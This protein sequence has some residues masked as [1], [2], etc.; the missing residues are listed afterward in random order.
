MVLIILVSGIILI[1]R[2]RNSNIQNL[3]SRTPNIQQRVEGKFPGFN[4]PANADRA[5][6]TEVSGGQG[7]GEATRTFENGTF[8]LTVMADLPDPAAGYFYQGWIVKDNTYLS[9]GKLEAAK[10]GFLVNFTSFTNYSDYKKVVVT[11][12]KVFDNTPE[13]HIL[14][15]S[16]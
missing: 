11:Q 16:F 4:V 7:I 6:L 5:E 12:E 8:S 10:G 15:G 3:P 9:L 13:T 14:E 2:A 1:R